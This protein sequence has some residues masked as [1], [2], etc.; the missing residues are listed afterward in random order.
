[1]IQLNLPEKTDTERLILQRLKYEDAEE[2]FYSYASKPEVT[3]FLSWRTH[4]A[5]EDTQNFLK[6]AIMNWNIGVDYSYSIRIKSSNKLIGGFGFIN[7]EGKIQFGYAISPIHWNNGYATETCIKM[8]A[9]IRNYPE[10]YRVATFVDAENLASMRVLENA[11]L[12]KEATLKKWFRF[13][14]QNNEPKDCALY[15]LQL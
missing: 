3:K 15:H 9:L 11:G 14:N 6:Y 10:V 8:M 4:V 1:M 5:V 7:E 2:I 13:I 12:V